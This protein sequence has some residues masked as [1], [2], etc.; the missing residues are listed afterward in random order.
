VLSLHG[1]LDLAAVPRVQ[2]V[3]LKRLA[4]AP[5]TIIC[6][7]SGI[8]ML[9]PL[10]A[11]VFTATWRHAPGWPRTNLLL[12][13]AQPQVAAVL[14]R[15]RVPST[16]PLHDTLA[17]ALAHAG[18]RPQRLDETFELDPTPDAPILARLFVREVCAL[19]DVVQVAD[20]AAL[21]C[22]ELVSNAV[23]HART[24][25]KVRLQLRAHLLYLNVHDQGTTFPYLRPV[26]GEG[27]RDHGLAIVD[28]YSLAW[29]VRGDPTGGKV[30][31]C[32]LDPTRPAP[33]P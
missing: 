16:L 22:A 12:C 13:A 29:G 32:S 17:D 8:D 24:R 18:S 3:L 2:R 10:C 19:W 20:V 33:I 5:P 7:L 11:S 28:W 23:V 9:D 25:T 1:Q 15:L 6:D 4:D 31:W 14:A 21:L 26:D 27:D 30:M